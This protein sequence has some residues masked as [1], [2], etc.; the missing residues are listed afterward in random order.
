MVRLACRTKKRADAWACLSSI[1]VAPQKIIAFD[2]CGEG[3]EVTD[4]GLCKFPSD[5]FI[6]T[7]SSQNETRRFTELAINR[8]K[9]LDRLRRTTIA[10]LWVA[11]ALERLEGLGGVEVRRKYGVY[12]HRAGFEFLKVKGI[13][14]DGWF[15]LRQTLR[16]PLGPVPQKLNQKRPH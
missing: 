6:Q 8:G 9:D 10:L 12:P 15:F 13:L 16:E 3:C 2:D 11:E 1:A 5:V 4:F 7:R 14:R